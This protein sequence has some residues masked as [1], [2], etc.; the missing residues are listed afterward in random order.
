MRTVKIAP[1]L[2][3][4][5]FAKLAQEA[6]DLK[7]Q[8]ADWLHVDVMDG[9]FVP[10]LT[11]GPPIVKSL[12]KHTDMFL[13]CHLMISNPTVYAPQFR[14]AGADQVTFHVEAC[15]DE[16]EIHNLIAT[17]KDMGAR[18]GLSVKP[19]TSIDAIMPFVDSIDMVLVMTVEPG[20]GGQ[21]F[22]S[23]MMSKVEQLA[24]KLP[25]HVDI[26]V[27]GGINVET[28]KIVGHAGANAI[29]SGSTIFKAQ[30]REAMITE[31][32]MATQSGLARSP[33]S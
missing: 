28:A 9:H 16:E 8:G 11:L 5:D 17:L 23:D 14:E 24:R 7:D 21:S 29:V 18:V 27:D 1:S 22:M 33:K 2:L 20:F 15:K 19:A 4:G 10:N 12:R 26:Q 13:D 32:R 3:S 25:D 31:I 30:N 6:C